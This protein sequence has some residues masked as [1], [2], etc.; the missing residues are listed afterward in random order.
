[1]FIVLA[2]NR[3][4]VVASVILSIATKKKSHE[5]F[6]I[7]LSLF[8]IRLFEKDVRSFKSVHVSYVACVHYL[9]L[10]GIE[11]FHSKIKPVQSWQLVGI[12]ILIVSGT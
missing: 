2:I 12:T 5:L 11:N 8:L 4:V 1:M 6:V 9:L 10:H 7:L 3:A